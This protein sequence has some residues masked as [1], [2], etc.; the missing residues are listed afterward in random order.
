MASIASKNLYELLGN[1]PEL[2]PERATPQPPARAID[3]PMDRSGKRNAGPT[4]PSD[5]NRG[6]GGRGG[7]RGGAR[8][9]ETGSERAFHDRE[10]GSYNNR[11]R[12]PDDGLR[13][14]R[15]PDRA[16]RGEYRGRGRGG[17][18]G[19]GGRRGSAGHGDRQDKTGLAEHPKQAAHGWGGETGNDELADE[20]AGE[21]I[22][23]AEEAEGFDTSVPP[24]VGEDA[25]EAEPEGPKTKSYEEYLAEQAEKKLQL[26]G[27]LSVRKAN[28]GASKKFQE[29]KAFSRKEEEENYMAGSSGK[30]ARFREKKEKVAVDMTDVDPRSYLAEDRQA[31]SRGRGRGRGDR[32][33][34]RGDRGDRAERGD[35]GDR[36]ERRGGYRGRGDGDR[37][38]GEFRGRGGRGGAPPRVN[39]NS[40]FPSLGS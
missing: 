5:A 12:A 20:Q 31:S 22:A 30:A 24:P 27:D 3:K 2:D 32:G 29:G 33:G 10:A 1:D 15:H 28:E 23:K 21:A 19:R 38:R 18:G 6:R 17:R 8:S 35:R 13:Q 16:P 4:A 37:P 36:G 40:A 9:N 39:D 25:V 14:D 26:G 11:S 34:D 7:S